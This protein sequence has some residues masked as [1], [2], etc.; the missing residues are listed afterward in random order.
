MSKE[1]HELLN[2]E[3]IAAG[4]LAG[5]KGDFPMDE[6]VIG[7]RKIP[8]MPLMKSLKDAKVMPKG[9]KVVSAEAYAYSAWTITGRISAILPDGTP[10]KYFLKVCNPQTS[11]PFSLAQL[12]APWLSYFILTKKKPTSSAPARTTARQ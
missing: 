6:A 7:G 5:V 9:T 4:H 1:I 11:S 2:N 3:N 8:Y 12:D 10:K